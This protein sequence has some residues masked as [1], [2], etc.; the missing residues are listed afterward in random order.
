MNI[1]RTGDWQQGHEALGRIAKD[2]EAAPYLIVQ[3][4]CYNEETTLPDVIAGVPRQIPGIA[5]VE[6]QVIDDGSTDE[7]VEIARALGVDHIVRNK[8]NKGLARSFQT[9]I[10]HALANGADIIVNT[11]GDNQYSGSSIADLVQPSIAGEADIVLGDRDPGRNLEFP[12]TKR[13]LQRVGSRVI[14]SLAGI[15][16][17]DAVTGSRAYSRHAA[18]QINVM[19]RFSYT[20]ETLIHAGRAGMTIRS[21]PVKTNAA[22]R[23]SRLFQS[24]GQFIRKQLVTIIRSCAMYMP[25]RSFL[26]AGLVI[27]AIGLI[28]VARFLYFF[29]IGDGDG[30]IQS[31]V[32]GAVF[33][34]MGYVTV[35]VAFL[36]DIIATNRRLSETTLV[37][38][39]ELESTVA[40]INRTRR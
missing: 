21:V 40:D 20:V 22:T 36:S 9:G 14:R 8:E 31:L 25:L 32:L 19:T 16:V 24:T 7:T 5:C 23:S 12:P 34:I 37:R 33:L 28:P 39:R 30:H 11:D 15:P 35:L 2:S 10:E 6:I 18:Q 1:K 3:I 38:L 13:L 27:L 17:Q 29:A 4:P 26:L